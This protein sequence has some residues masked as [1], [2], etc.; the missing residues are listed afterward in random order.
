MGF[1]TLD[2]VTICRKTEPVIP[3]WNIKN[4]HEHFVQHKAH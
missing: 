4:I 2:I 1:P 3:H